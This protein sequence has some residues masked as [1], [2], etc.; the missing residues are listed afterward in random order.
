VSLQVG[1]KPKSKNV[2]LMQVV[3]LPFCHITYQPFFPK[4]AKREIRDKDGKLLYHARQ[5]RMSTSHFYY[6]YE[7]KPQKI[8]LFVQK[9]DLEITLKNLIKNGCK[10]PK[11]E[12]MTQWLPR[13]CPSCDNEGSIVWNE[14]KRD[15][16]K[17]SPKIRFWFN[18]SKTKPKRCFLGTWDY[19]V[20]QIRLKKGIDIRKMFVS[21]YLKEGE[22]RYF[23]L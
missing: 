17:D 23:D 10:K 8:P 6:S 20:N 1:R 15:Y 14:D 18:H 4:G 5:M 16:K 9:K 3:K 21:Y 11:A 2:G 12:P 13:T 19:A 7:G 22:K